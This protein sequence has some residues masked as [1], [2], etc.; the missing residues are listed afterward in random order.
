M[1]CASRPLEEQSA[2]AFQCEMMHGKNNPHFDSLLNC[3]LDNGCMSK[4][5]DDGKCFVNPA[6]DGEKN[7]TSL[8]HVAGHWWA[9]RGLNPHYDTLPCS[10]NRWEELPDGSWRDNVTWTNTYVQPAVIT[11]S[12]PIVSIDPS[13]PGDIL[14]NYTD[15]PLQP[16][17]EHWV[18]V[19][20]PHSD[21]MF[22]IWCGGNSVVTM[23]GALIVSK[24][25]NEKG[26]PGWVE[27]RFRDVATRQGFDYGNM[28]SVD[29]S[30]CQDTGVLSDVSAAIVV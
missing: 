11:G 4:Y 15:A 7:V 24:N 25:K 29:A 2:C 1:G 9:I 17:V 8:A 6:T 3:M 21:Y 13:R 19:S 27:R 12:Y 26:M 18:V 14:T 23:G 5:P 16:Q 28:T 30:A 20:K 10:I 22:L